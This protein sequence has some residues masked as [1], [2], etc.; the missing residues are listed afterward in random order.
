M[1]RVLITGK[2]SY[3]GT[4]VEQWLNRYPEKYAVEVLDMIGDGWKKSDFHGVDV[5][6]HV[7]GIA[8]RN[9][10][11]DDLYEQVN[12]K[13]AVE[14]AKKAASAGVSQFIF[15]S[16]G[17][18]YSQSDKKHKVIVVDENTALSPVTA[19][20]I[21]KLRAEEDLAK[22]DTAMKIAVIRPPMVYGPGAKGNYNSLAGIARRTPLFPDIKNKR[23]MIF[24]DNLCEF[25]RLLIDSGD[26]GIFLPQN[27]E[28]VRTSELVRQIAVNNGKHIHLTRVFNW[29]VLLSSNLVNVVNKVFGDFYYKKKIYFGNA[30]Q[31]VDFPESIKKTEAKVLKK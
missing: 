7:A 14:V 19:Y 10:A 31:V 25:V 16:S 6:Y 11:P 30:Y 9:D 15:M 26:S 27:K 5:V 22:L 3:I 18:V 12:H 23:S 2:G 13:L 24:I 8:H 21:S 20:G 28:Y 1:K 29:L 4:K 17:A